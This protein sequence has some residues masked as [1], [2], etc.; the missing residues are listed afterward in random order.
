MFGSAA[1]FG[2]RRTSRVPGMLFGSRSQGGKTLGAAPAL[3]GVWGGGDV[4]EEGRE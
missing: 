4:V 2:G 3:R 1:L